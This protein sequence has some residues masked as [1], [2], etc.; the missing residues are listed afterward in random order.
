[1]TWHKRLFGL[2]LILLP[3]QLGLHFWPEWS[4][5]LGRRIDYLS[6]TVYLTDIIIVS[7]LSF[8]FLRSR[9]KF[10]PRIPFL[11]L[12]LA[13]LNIWVS[14][15][16][17]VAIYKWLKVLE[18]GMLGW[19]IVKTKPSTSFVIWNLSFGILFSS[20]LAIGQFLFQRSIGGPLRLLGE[21]TFNG[22]TP[23]IA[24]VV[25]GGR[26]IIRSYATFPHP[27]VL[28]GFLAITLPLVLRL[29]RTMWFYVVMVCGIA[30]L[31]LTFSRSAWVVS[32]LGAVWTF[33]HPENV[34][35]FIP[36]TMS[37]AE[38]SIVVRQ[39][40]NASALSLW[41]QSPLVGVG[42]GNFLVNL[43]QILSSRQ[44]YFLQ[45][46][47]NIFLLILAE[48]GIIGLLLFAYLLWKARSPM[49]FMI[50]L[51]GLVDHYPLTLQQ[52]QL[53]LTL[54]LGLGLVK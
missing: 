24:R 9:P 2:L 51:L 36:G 41:Q 12:L 42:L 10:N 39:E 11:V 17:P 1:M 46:V 47:H 15:N 27:N 18:F 13:A 33:I 5:V 28:G 20:L 23:G 19:Y 3:T 38:E 31:I 52:G 48:T 6:P 34:L 7:I 26:E 14:Q 45:P 4:M 8:W 40:L 22:D 32:M 54:V 50:V 49:V 53:L 16:Q 21:R 37:F 30:A 25:L 44:I 29:K 35:A 43:P